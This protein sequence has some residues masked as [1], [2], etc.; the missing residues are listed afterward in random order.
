MELRLFQRLNCAERHPLVVSLKH[1]LLAPSLIKPEYTHQ[2]FHHVYHCVVVV[3][4]EQDLVE[5][6]VQCLPVQ[7]R[8]RARL[9]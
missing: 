3:I 1:D 8:G 9:C 6:N 7:Y 5:R 4:V 2:R